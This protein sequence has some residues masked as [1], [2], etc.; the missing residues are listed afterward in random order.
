MAFVEKHHLELV[1][2]GFFVGF[3]VAEGPFFIAIKTS[4][5]LSMS[6]SECVQSWNQFFFHMLLAIRIAAAV[7]GGAR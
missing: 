4:K 6:I 1:H 2:V 3:Y 7:A 5:F